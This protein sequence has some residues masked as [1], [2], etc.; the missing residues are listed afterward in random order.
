MTDVIR[1]DALARLA[2]G[3][4]T[5]AK[6]L[7]LAMFSGKWKLAI[8]CHLSQHQHYRFN[9][10]KRLL[11]KIT[12]KGL[13]N[14]LRE[15][16]QDDLITRTPAANGSNMVSYAITPLGRSLMPIIDAMRQW[17]QARIDQLLT[18]PATDESTTQQ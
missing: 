8:L 12:H 15:L 4:D 17:G 16:V 6:E 9:E 11:P 5:C 14:Q 2:Q 10:I 3:D 1:K 13:A 18:Q 7:T